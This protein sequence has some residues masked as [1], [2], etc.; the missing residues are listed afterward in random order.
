MRLLSKRPRGRPRKSL[1]QLVADGSFL[2]RRH[3]GLLAGE[4][5]SDPTLRSLQQLYVQAGD[6]RQRRRVALQFEKIARGSRREDDEPD[7]EV[8]VE[9]VS[10]LPEPAGRGATDVF[11]GPW[12][13]SGVSAADAHRHSNWEPGGHR[14]LSSWNPPGWAGSGAPDY[15]SRPPLDGRPSDS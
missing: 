13:D 11:A 9:Q 12:R 10:G 5:V 1:E 14:P 7:V 4:L 8:D 15:G 3:A 6:A 2:A